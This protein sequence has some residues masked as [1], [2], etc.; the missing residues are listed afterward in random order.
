MK[1]SAQVGT[2][3][4]R[5]L[6]GREPGQRLAAMA[7]LRREL[8]SMETELAGEALR[9]GL[10]WREIGEA[11]GVS[12]Q[13]A[14]RRHSGGVARLSR[15]VAR[16]RQAISGMAVSAA[17]R[18]A[19]HAAGRR[20]ASRGEPEVGAEHLLLGLLESGDEATVALLRRLGADPGSLRA[21]VDPASG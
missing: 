9:S 16:P 17:A 13:A 6:N 20:A 12:K 4:S 1:R 7:A 11:L 8:E 18:R 10:T 5:V 2:L 21:E 15:S 14:H 3:L 19:F